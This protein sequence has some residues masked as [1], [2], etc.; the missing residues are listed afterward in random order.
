MSEIEQ[1]IG[2]FMVGVGC[3]MEHQPSGKILCLL[4]DRANYQKGEWELMY[5]RIDQHEELFQALRREVKEE[6]GLEGFSIER[7]LRVWHFYRG[8]KKPETE[9]HGFTFHCVIKTQEVTLSSEHAEY[10]WLDPEEA[11]KVIKVLGIKEDVRFFLEHKKD[12]QIALS[13]VSNLIEHVL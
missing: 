7:L 9:I 2:H 8:E 11:L 12:R 6:T 3:V 13:G 10:C 5:G 4:R 1:K